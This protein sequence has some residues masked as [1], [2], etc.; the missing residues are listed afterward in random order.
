MNKISRKKVW[1]MVIL[2]RNKELI[3]ETKPDSFDAYSFS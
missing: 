2:L 3:K 1:E